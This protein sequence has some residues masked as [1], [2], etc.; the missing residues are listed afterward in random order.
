MCWIPASSRPRGRSCSYGEVASGE[1][2]QGPPSRSNARRIA[3]GGV[4]ETP[5][6]TAR[7]SLEGQELYVDL[8]MVAGHLLRV[9]PRVQCPTASLL[10]QRPDPVPHERSIDSG[11]GDL[12]AVVAL[13]V[14]SDSLGPEVGFPP[15]LEDLLDGLRADRVR[16]VL[17]DRSPPANAGLALCS[18]GSSPAVERGPGNPKSSAGPH[19]LDPRRSLVQHQP[20]P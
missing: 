16:P 20:I 6:R 17:A 18:R 11:A 3:D 14:P 9:A 15:Q 8:D 10:G 4:L 1:A 7:T 12:N 2:P 19:D 5:D 13:E